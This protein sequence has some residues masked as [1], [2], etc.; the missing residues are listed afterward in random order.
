[1][2]RV[3]LVSCLCPLAAC[4]PA[5]DDDRQVDGPGAPT[6]AER[7]LG[8][9]ART[10]FGFVAS[11]FVSIDDVEAA[12][13]LLAR[14]DVDLDL[15]WP[16]TEIDNPHWY[17]VARS[18]AA[19]G[20]QIEPWL[21]L[22]DADGYFANSTNATLF[23][24]TMRRLAQRWLDEGLPP[25]K[26][27]IDMEMPI[28]RAREFMKVVESADV[29][30]LTDF[31]RAGIDRPQYAQATEVYRELVDWLHAQGFKVALNVLPLVLDDYADGDDGLRQ[32]LQLPVAG[33]AWDYYVFQLYRTLVRYS[34]GELAGPHNGYYVYDYARRAHAQ[35]GDRAVAFLG[36]TDPGIA[37]EVPVYSAPSELREDVDAALAAGLL[38]DNIAVFSLRG[39]VNRPD[40]EQWFPPASRLPVPP[41]PDTATALT[42]ATA[43]VLDSAL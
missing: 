20:V 12:L 36:L 28:A 41:F 29:D 9:E 23:A 25:W 2:F 19:L 15:A 16:A 14:H 3:L 30:A 6:Q 38:R 11:E 1:M 33:I 37:P 42:R 40:P 24:A 22:S 43:L 39:L 21:T 17:D 27:H 10:G 35:F 31:M 8:T 18:A 32:A 13:P 7:R 26:V 5:A 4:G 34:F